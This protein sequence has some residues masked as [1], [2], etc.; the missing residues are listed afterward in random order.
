VFLSCQGDGFHR[1]ALGQATRSRTLKS[2]NAL[3]SRAIACY[4]DKANVGASGAI[5]PSCKRK[6]RRKLGHRKKLFN[7][8]HAKARAVSEQGATTLNGA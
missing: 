5:G 4:A 3:T 6:N 8:Y 7:R 1:P 2:I